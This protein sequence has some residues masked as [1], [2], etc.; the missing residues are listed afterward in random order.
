LEVK[1]DGAL[2][3]KGSAADPI[4]LTGAQETRGYWQGVRFNGTDDID[5]VLA[6]VTIEYA[7]GG[8]FSSHGD[9]SN[10]MVSD[11]RVSISDSTLRQS[12]GNG[13]YFYQA[14]ITGFGGNTVTGNAWGA[15]Y[16]YG[17]DAGELSGTS[18]YSGNDKDHVEL[19]RDTVETDQVW[20]AIDVPYLVRQM[21][22]E[23]QLT[24]A[25][26]ATLHFEQDQ[27]MQ[28]KTGGALTAAGTATAPVVFSGA[29]A[30]RG[31]WQGIYFTGTDDIDNRMEHVVVE[32]GGG[33]Y[34]SSSG[35][36]SNIKASNSTLTIANATIRESDGYG[37]SD[38]NSTITMSDI[39]YEH[40]AGEDYHEE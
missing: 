32:Y 35:D 18:S 19:E 8:Y 7:G 3:A 25:A 10:L 26:G 17:N 6:H 15:G 12:A 9:D 2:S 16:L 29:Q 20:P 13:F 33:S 30:T 4:L 23:A 11:A 22:L 31:Y 24:I 34:F 38:Y 21:A 27:G 28:I 36:N 5:N 39:T 37:I 14:N 40:N 1:S